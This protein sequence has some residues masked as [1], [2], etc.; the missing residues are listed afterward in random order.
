M[1]GNIVVRAGTSKL[2]CCAA[3][4]EALVDMIAT[5]CSLEMLVEKNVEDV[6]PMGCVNKAKRYG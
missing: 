4:D 1:C 2:S 5:S 3:A 6:N